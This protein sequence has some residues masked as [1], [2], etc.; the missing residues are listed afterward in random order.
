MKKREQKFST[1]HF[2]AVLV[3]HEPEPKDFRDD[4][5]SGAL[6]ADTPDNYLLIGPPGGP[7]ARIEGAEI[8]LLY[9]LLEQVQTGGRRFVRPLG[10]PCHG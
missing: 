10:P 4:L 1:E 8:S 5:R 9:V 3:V 2:D 7:L 6:V